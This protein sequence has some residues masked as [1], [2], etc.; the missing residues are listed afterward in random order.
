MEPFWHSHKYEIQS[1]C[2]FWVFIV[3]VIRKATFY[4][5]WIVV[6][7]HF[8]YECGLRNDPNCLLHP[9]GLFHADDWVCF[10]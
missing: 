2:D 6:A 8:V 1:F 7:E 10:Y 9:E 3:S 4:L 5:S